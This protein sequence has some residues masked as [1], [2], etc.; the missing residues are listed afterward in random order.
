MRP[1]ARIALACLALTACGKKDGG[2]IGAAPGPAPGDKPGDDV[3]KGLAVPSLATGERADVVPTGPAVVI[4]ASQVG[5]A[6]AAVAEVVNG[7]IHAAELEGGL[8]N[9]RIARLQQ[10]AAGHLK[11]PEAETWEAVVVAVDP[12]LP[13]E[14][15]LLVARTFRAVEQR[16]LAFLV[17]TAEGPGVVPV[18]V[19]DAAPAV[20]SPSPSKN[21]DEQPIGMVVVLMPDRVVVW[22]LSGLEGTLASPRLALQPANDSAWRTKL[23]DDLTGVATRRWGGRERPD[24]QQTIHVVVDGK[25]ASG[26]LVAAIA[27]VR[28]DA[29]GQALFPDVQLVPEGLLEVEDAIAKPAPKPVDDAAAAKRREEA[30]LEEEVTRYAALLVGESSDDAVSGDLSK[31]APGSDLAAQLRDVRQAGQ[32]VSVGGGTRDGGGT[33]VAGSTTDPGTALKTPPGRISVAGKKA[34][35]DTSLAVDETLRKIQAAYMAG[36]KRCY[37]NELKQDPT[38][39]GAVELAFTVN[40]MGRATGA[41]VEAMAAELDDCLTGLVASWRFPIPKDADGEATQAS[42]SIKFVFTP[43]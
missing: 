22:S 19:M 24:D 31:R 16:R 37:K 23:R 3:L 26:D 8:A 40:E 20:A 21:P 33:A 12:S 15:A 41:R 5:F 30:A 6:G 42:F 4:S 35:D 43:D 32:E 11:L 2:D 1:W 27:A 29:K 10:L 9:P 34:F 17:R 39:R 25:V 7:T 28:H 14:L 18:T 13:S 38:L 36:L